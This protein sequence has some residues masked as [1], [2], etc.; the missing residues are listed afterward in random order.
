MKITVSG[1]TL[2]V[3]QINAVL[4]EGENN[5]DTIQIELPEQYGT[6]E[7]G[8]LSYSLAGYTNKE[9]R[10]DQVLP[11]R[12]NS[13]TVLLTWEV[14]KL[15][16]AVYGTMDLEL[17]GADSTGSVKIKWLSSHPIIIRQ[18]LGTGPLPV[19]DII[20]QYLIS[21]QGLTLQAASAA[22]RAEAAERS[23][24]KSAATAE[25]MLRDANAYTD[26]Q[27]KKLLDDSIYKMPYY[28]PIDG[29][30]KDLQRVLDSL[31]AQRFGAYTW[32]EREA[33]DLTWGEFEDKDLTWEQ[34]NKGGW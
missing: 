22:D 24:K 9:T 20:Q 2:N 30:K 32:E 25:N 14:K 15:W 4:V 11:K 1:K 21:V 18:A 5:A 33:K 23:A 3:D 17:S 7:L 10:I 6:L 34:I 16:A 26:A 31:A 12:I 13:G 28:D 19:P 29:A 8:K 27:V